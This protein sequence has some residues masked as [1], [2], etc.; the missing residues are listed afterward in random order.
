MRRLPILLPVLLCLDARNSSAGDEGAILGA[1]TDRSLSRSALKPGTALHAELRAP[2]YSRD[3][4]TIPAGT[5]I[6]LTISEP[7]KIKG[8]TPVRRALLMLAGRAQ[9][10][11]GPRA[12]SVSSATLTFP[13]GA[14]QP[15]QIELLDVLTSVPLRPKSTAAGKQ[16]KRSTLILKLK[17]SPAPEPALPKTTSGPPAGIRA[18]LL[19]PV[20]ASANREGDVV[21]ARLLEPLIIAGRVALPEGA[22]LDATVVRHKP[23]RYFSRAGSLAL[24]I[25]Q[26]VPSATGIVELSA[27]L[28]G[29]ETGGSGMHIDSEGKISGGPRGRK[30]AALDLAVA[31]V[32]GKV[33]DDLVEEGIKYVW[34][35]ASAGTVATAAR[36]A[37]LGAG[38]FVFF[39]QRGRDVYLP[40][41]SEITLTFTRPVTFDP[42]PSR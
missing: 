15:V 22:E 31:Y 29:L 28:G 14:V 18:M 23:P 39:A 34:T 3:R 4:I 41:Y 6:D 26:T 11:S 36:Y 19:A 17:D 35:A 16:T 40:Q 30:R 10:V 38:A 20:R 32:T 21:R 24:R 8:P 33:L 13:S 1:I 2:V 27:V 25:S 42:L 37:G 7:F 5:A 9:P 12:A